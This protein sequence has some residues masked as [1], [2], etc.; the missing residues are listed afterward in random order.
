MNCCDRC[1]NPVNTE[2]MV[3]NEVW[4]QVTG[5]APDDDGYGDGYWCLPCFIAE[6][7]KAYQDKDFSMD[8]FVRTAYYGN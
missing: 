5:N 2:F 8:V 7:E 1:N 6:A 4:E 3:S